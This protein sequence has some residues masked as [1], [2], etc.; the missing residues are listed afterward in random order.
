MPIP[1]YT[2]RGCYSGGYRCITQRAC[3]RSAKGRSSIFS[4][5]R[6]ATSSLNNFGLETLGHRG[7][8]CAS[9]STLFGGLPTKLLESPCLPRENM[10]NTARQRY[11]YCPNGHT[12]RAA[13]ATNA[14]T[15]ISNEA[16]ASKKKESSRVSLSAGG[17]TSATFGPDTSVSKSG[18]SGSNDGPQVL[19]PW[20]HET[21]HLNRL[22]PG[23][24]EYKRPGPLGAGGFVHYPPLIFVM[25]VIAA[26]SLNWPFYDIF[27]THQWQ[28]TL[29]DTCAVAFQNCVGCLVSHAFQGECIM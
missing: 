24:P 14:K 12:S 2:W 21:K 9:S 3:V 8:F 6:I 11:I 15:N 26:R 28:Q 4:V 18:S 1:C 17:S 19:F 23:T 5:Q 27:L 22:V 20:R 10:R 16:F 7:L 13:F 25:H 29:A